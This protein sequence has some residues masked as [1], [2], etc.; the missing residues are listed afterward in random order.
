MTNEIQRV[1]NTLESQ[2]KQIDR[3]IASSEAVADLISNLDTNISNIND[4]LVSG[5]SSLKSGLKETCFVLNKG[6]EDLAY[7]LTLIDGSLQEIKE[8]LEKPLDTQAKELRKRAEFAYLNGWYDEA[9]YDLL[10]SEKKNYLDF[11]ALHILGNIY[12]YHKQNYQKA[13]EYYLKA[14]KYAKPQSNLNACKALLCAA[15]VYEKIGKVEDAYKSTLTAIEFLSSE[16][17]I[18]QISAQIFFNHAA[19]ASMTGHKDEAIKNLQKAILI[20][21]TFLITAEFDERFSYI[22]QEKEELKRDLRDKQK[23][24]VEQ[25]RKQLL[26]L[27]QDFNYAIIT[28]EKV[29]ITIKD[30]FKFKNS[31]YHLKAMISKIDNLYANNSYFDLLK[32]ERLAQDIYNE[33]RKEYKENINYCIEI[34]NLNI[35]ELESRKEKVAGGYLPVLAGLAIWLI[36]LPLIWSNLRPSFKLFNNDEEAVGAWIVI[37]FFWFVYVPSVFLFNS[38]VEKFKRKIIDK[39]IDKEKIAIIRL[40]DLKK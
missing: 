22:E 3:V 26:L 20:E 16:N 27:D 15:K 12:Y 10:E 35:K 21:P 36:F 28:A 34:K 5:F 11:I 8:I 30:L 39:K 24:K 2:L 32:A 37:G 38:I 9:E 6:F 1:R 29:G 4:N 25:L 19:Y 7:K 14:A 31:L 17:E 40:S 18:P 13:L 33:G 23:Q